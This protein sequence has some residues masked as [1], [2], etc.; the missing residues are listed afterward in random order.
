MMIKYPPK[1][2]RP[3]PTKSSSKMSFSRTYL[4]SL[5]AQRKQE[6]IERSTVQMVESMRHTIIGLATEG[7]T[8]YIYEVPLSL[9]HKNYPVLAMTTVEDFIPCFQ[10]KF[11]HCT[12]SCHDT[13]VD[14]VIE[15][16]RRQKRGILIE[17]S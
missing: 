10:K 14:T 13:W 6:A 1:I 16:S 9:I 17:W 4:Q 2:E 7:K 5:S 11:P 8:S 12:L 15:S 3:A